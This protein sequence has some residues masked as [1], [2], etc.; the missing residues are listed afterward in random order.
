[1]RLV[2]LGPPGAGKGTQAA[3]ISETWQIPHISTGDMLRAAVA[4][5]S[6]LGKKV[7]EIISKGHLVP[8]DV[9]GE[10]VERRL[11]E[12][13]ARRGFL[14]DGFPRTLPQVGI[15]DRGLAKQGTSLDRVIFLQLEDETALARILGR[16]EDGG[17]GERADDAEETARERLRVY[18][19]QTA[20]VA[21]EYETRGL[22]AKI[23]GSRT[24]DAVF[25]QIKAALEG[26]ASTGSDD[27]G[28]SG[29]GG[30]R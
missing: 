8:D 22:L 15:L 10:V 1:M 20:P 14:L 28:E 29:A 26:I 24:I 6:E 18:H 17:D 9:I 12:E 27:P 16:R 4:S 30:G 5:G 21:S 3:R 2:L 25:E 11:S 19:R 7:N 23:D 13:D